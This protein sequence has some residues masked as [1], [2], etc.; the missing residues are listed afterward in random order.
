VPRPCFSATIPTSARP[1]GQ[2]R[3]SPVYTLSHWTR[4]SPTHH[5]QQKEK[6]RSKIDTGPSANQPVCTARKLQKVRRKNHHQHA[7]GRSC[8]HHPPSEKR[9]EKELQLPTR[10]QSQPIDDGGG[11]S[12]NKP[13]PP[14]KRRRAARTPGRPFLLGQ[15]RRFQLE[16]AGFRN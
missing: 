4:K 7:P 1:P 6:G 15:F 12:S 9:K 5:E 8:S 16:K 3:P 10:Y 13:T 11:R 2:L 14:P